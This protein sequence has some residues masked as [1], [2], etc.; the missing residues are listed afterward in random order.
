MERRVAHRRVVAGRRL[1]GL[2]VVAA[3]AVA[4]SAL[5]QGSVTPGPPPRVF[6]FLSRAGGA[7]LTHLRLY[8]SRISVVAPNWY[9]LNTGAQTL[10]GAPSPVVVELARAAG[11]QIWPVVNARLRPG[12]AIGARYVRGRIA[13]VIAATALAH[14]YDGMTLDV[15]QLTDGQ[16]G[17]FSALV[18]AVGVAL[19][20]QHE[21]LA[22]YLPRRTADGGD[23]AYDWPTLARD[24]DLLIGSGYNEHSMTSSPGPVSTTGGFNDVLDYAAGVTP[25]RIAPVIGAFGYSWPAAGGAGA[26]LSTVQAD[27]MRLQTGALAHTVGGDTTFRADGRIVYYQSTSQL[28]AEARAARAHGMRWLALFSLGREPDAFWAHI[29]TARQSPAPSAGRTARAAG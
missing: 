5:G 6:A 24:A 10:S 15:E 23:H 7:E 17:A 13:D 29:T 28:I 26:M 2:L 19:H 27:Q 16:T 18:Q 9:A 25:S 8:G 21:Q 4:S 3:L 14:R 1:G 11:V 20:S 22:V 12:D